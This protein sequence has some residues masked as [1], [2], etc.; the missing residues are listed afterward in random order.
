MITNSLSQEHGKFDLNIEKVLEHWEVHHAIREII[1]NAIDEQRLTDTKQIEIFKDKKNNW[2]IRDYGRGIKYSH[3]TQKENDEKTKNPDKVI[4]KFGVGLKD[5]LATFDRKNIHITV[6]SKYG[7]IT[8]A[9][10]PK[11][12]FSSIETLHA[13]IEEPVDT[14]FI[15][16]EVILEGCKDEH[17]NAAKDFFLMFSNEKLLEK[18]DLGEIYTKGKTSRIYVGGLLIAEEENFLFSYNITSITKPMRKALNRERTN[19]GRT[20]YTQRVKDV[21]LQCKSE[22]VA[23]LLTTDLSKYDA[24]QCHD[25][26]LWIDIAVHACKLL[27][28]LKKVIF[29]TSME[30][31][32]ARNMVD[33]AK[34]SGFQVIIVP[35]TVKEKI[36][37]EKDY[38][39]N[40]IRDLGRYI[41]DRHDNFEFKFISPEKLSKQ[42][43]EIFAKTDKI[44]DL[45]GGKPHNIKKVLISE[46]MQ[47]DIN[48]FSEAAGL[49]DGT[50]IIIK[51]D[52]L[53]ELK[54]YAGILL[55]ETAHAISGKADVTREFEL[56]LTQLLGIIATENILN[57]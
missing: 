50:N 22:K 44:F 51:R 17:I 34:A 24:G 10:F 21:L 47:I 55:H 54:N 2:H 49:W 41:Q 18:T 13:L 45:I 26:L 30:M 23:E 48:S 38:E 46:T 4:G 20:A 43:K 9:K 15:G 42:E 3:L 5:A 7:K 16:T 35:E 8:T 57:K 27:N 25:E 52:Q 32:D 14:K 36:R 37:D 6:F 19:V 1:A 12:G 53:K 31:F 56:E 39:G 11:H 40:P 33:E 29:L 28:S